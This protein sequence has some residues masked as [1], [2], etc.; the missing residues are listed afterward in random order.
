MRSFEI[1]PSA[2][3]FARDVLEAMLENADVVGTDEKGRQ[4]LC[5]AVE[6][7]MLDA[8]ALFGADVEDDADGDPAEDDD[9]LEEDHEW[10]TWDRFLRA[11]GRY[12]S[13][14][15]VVSVAAWRA[16]SYRRRHTR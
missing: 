2:P 11:R 14:A 7:W 15:E 13:P 6:P 9:P 10:F 3:E 5:V 16:A 4:L 12:V 1:N 8:L